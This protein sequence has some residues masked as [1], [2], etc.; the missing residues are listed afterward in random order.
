MVSFDPQ[1]ASFETR[2]SQLDS[3]LMFTSALK[4]V[5]VAGISVM[6]FYSGNKLSGKETREDRRCRECDAQPR[7]VLNMLDPHSGRTIRMFEC[8][9]GERSWDD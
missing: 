1:S 2:G 3:E 5:P 8:E 6:N 7:L 9:C 4:T